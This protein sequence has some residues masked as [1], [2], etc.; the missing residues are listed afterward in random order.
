[1]VEMPDIPEFVTTGDDID[2]APKNAQ[3]AFECALLIYFDE[4]RSV[5]LPSKAIRGQKVVCLA[6]LVTSKIL[7]W[8]EILSG[9]SKG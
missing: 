7:F 1:M 9:K 6:A 4:R 5:S 8:N 3:E 2:N